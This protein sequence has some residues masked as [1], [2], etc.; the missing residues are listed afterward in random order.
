LGRVDALEM[1]LAK[2]SMA[3]DTLEAEN[4]R[5]SQALKEAEGRLAQV[6]DTTVASRIL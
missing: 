3:A 5:L 2:R 1:E 6:K 4:Y